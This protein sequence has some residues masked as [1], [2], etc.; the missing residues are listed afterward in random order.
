VFHDCCREALANRKISAFAAHWLWAA[1][2]LCGSVLRER[3]REPTMPAGFNLSIIGSV[4]DVMLIPS[5][6]IV[7]LLALG[8]I[9]MLLFF[10]GSRIPLNEFVRA[11][12]LV[13]FVR[14]VL[15]LIISVV[16]NRVRP[17]VRLWLRLW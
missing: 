4:V 7:N 8:P 5:I 14:G 10:G 17:T 13:S 15:T 9:V 12:G 1:R 16:L 11:S 2:D 3:L 6:I